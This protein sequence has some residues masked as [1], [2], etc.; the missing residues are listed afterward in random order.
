MLVL[1]CAGGMFVLLSGVKCVALLMFCVVL[2]QVSRSLATLTAESEDSEREKL[3][4]EISRIR[5]MAEDI[6]STVTQLQMEECPVIGENLLH[7]V[8]SLED[9]LSGSDTH[10]ALCLESPP[11]VTPQHTLSL[12]PLGKP[13]LPKRRDSKRKYLRYSASVKRSSTASQEGGELGRGEGACCVHVG[14]QLLLHCE[15]SGLYV[16]VCMYVCT[17]NSRLLQ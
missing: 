13:N 9:Q 14:G 4:R 8:D 6:V 7:V 5:A 3:A 2:P 11:A 15:G 12:S 17:H 1:S 16:Y 10:R